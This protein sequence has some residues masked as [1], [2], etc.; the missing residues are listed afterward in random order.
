RALVVADVMSDALK[1]APQTIARHYRRATSFRLREL[2]GEFNCQRVPK[3]LFDYADFAAS[4][5][6][7]TPEEIA[8]G[9]DADSEL[10]RLPQVFHAASW[11][12]FS[13]ELRQL[14][15]EGSVVARAFECGNYT[16]SNEVFWLVAKV[17]SKL[18]ASRDLTAYWLD[19]LE[20]LA[21]RLGFNR[22][23]NWLIANEG[24]SAEATV[25]LRTR[26]AFGSS[27]QQLELLS[28]RLIEP[29]SAQIRNDEANEF[30][31]ILPM[32]GDN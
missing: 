17:N 18:E 20:N 6:G 31:L 24:F 21:R 19:R 12:S 30:T 10:L 11:S 32:G 27:Q 28:A 9:L 14:A 13:P 16:D 23:Q 8:A 1:R 7:A 25:L 22:T 26:N 15:D 29:E 4:Y 3:R 2:L 5:K